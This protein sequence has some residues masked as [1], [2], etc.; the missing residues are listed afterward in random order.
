MKVT[1]NLKSKGYTEFSQ[2]NMIGNWYRKQEYGV[3]R[4]KTGGCLIQAE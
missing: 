2:A 3:G 1:F 4:E